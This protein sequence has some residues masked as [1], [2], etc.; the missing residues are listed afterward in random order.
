MRTIG[1]EV[2]ENTQFLSL[3][4]TRRL[5]ETVAVFTIEVFRKTIKEITLTKHKD[6]VEKYCGDVS[7]K[8]FEKVYGN[9][10]TQTIRT[11]SY[12]HLRAHET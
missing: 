5:T 11:V 1:E 12:T 7:E 10:D 9:R 8:E 3:Q 2:S 4:L 6:E